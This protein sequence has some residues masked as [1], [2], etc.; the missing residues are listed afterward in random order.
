MATETRVEYTRFTSVLPRRISDNGP[1]ED[2]EG[3][4]T[5]TFGTENE[6]RG[7][8]PDHGDGKCCV[9]GCGMPVDIACDKCQ[10]FVCFSHTAYECC[11]PID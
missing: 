5:R 2:D 10:E 11:Q 1:D 6:T 3:N 7:N 4:S 9:P 8:D